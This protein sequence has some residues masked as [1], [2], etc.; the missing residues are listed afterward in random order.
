MGLGEFGLP[1]PPQSRA[2]GEL[3]S[4]TR[5]TRGKLDSCFS[6]V[7]P[8][9]RTLRSLL[10][11][12]LSG[13]S[14]LSTTRS[15]QYWFEGRHTVVQISFGL[16]PRTEGREGVAVL[17]PLLPS[18]AAAPP[19]HT[20]PRSE[21]A[22]GVRLSK[23][24]DQV[25]RPWLWT[26][27]PTPTAPL[28]SSF[29]F[30]LLFVFVYFVFINE[31]HCAS[32]SPSKGRHPIT[33]FGPA[34]ASTSTVPQRP[35]VL[36]LKQPRR[37]QLTGSR[38]ASCRCLPRAPGMRGTNSARTAHRARRGQ[39]PRHTRDIAGRLIMAWHP[40]LSLLGARR[41]RCL[42]LNCMVRTASGRI[43]P[44]RRRARCKAHHDPTRPSR[45]VRP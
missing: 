41:L 31:R 38:C 17:F 29:F 42:Q 43:R 45:T 32:L 35:R 30:S 11:F 12:S 26:D 16:A 18:A 14:C 33:D 3:S 25:D 22:L 28:S 1:L 13:P 40:F 34:S 9:T 15:L 20:A 5:Y 10:P 39:A 37:L 2:E 19:P 6:P 23:L 4:S 24:A 21:S 7:Q 44:L 8:E 36:L 27:F